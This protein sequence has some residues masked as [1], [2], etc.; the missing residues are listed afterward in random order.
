MKDSF[1]FVNLELLLTWIAYSPCKHYYYY[2][3]VDYQ[4]KTV[5]NR[6]DQASSLCKAEWHLIF[7]DNKYSKRTI[8]RESMLAEFSIYLPKLWPLKANAFPH[9]NFGYLK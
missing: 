9:F 6:K 3:V 8:L 5:K 4:N 1:G 2:V 7:K